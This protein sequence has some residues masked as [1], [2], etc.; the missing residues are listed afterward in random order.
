LSDTNEALTTDS[1]ASMLGGEGDNEQ[2]ETDSQ[3]ADDDQENSEDTAQD[4]PEAESQDDAEG[5]DEAQDEQPEADSSKD[6]IELEIDGEKV[7]LTKDEVKAGYLR[8]QDY[9]QKA[10]NL[11][12]EK[13]DQAEFVKAQMESVTQMSREL[14]QLHQIDA[15]LQQYQNVDWQRLRAEDPLS[16]STHLAEFNDLRARR[17]DVVNQIGQKQQQLTAKQQETFATQT[18]EAAAHM[19]TVVP[20]FGEQH[21]KQMKDFG[22]KLGFN[23]QELAAIADKRVMEAL[24]KA[25]AY[26]KAQAETKQAVKKV[27]ALP[28]KAAKPAPAAKPAAEQRTEKLKHRLAQTGSV[29]DFAALLGSL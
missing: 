13:Q 26:D 20:G 24:Y 15:T 19:A 12:R 6:V 2:P 9:T 8:Q 22:L 23:A 21:L 4:E 1:F 11:A 29:K 27:S 18:K 5:E 3:S 10:Q 25:S 17:G 28:T 14:G 16:Y 7:A